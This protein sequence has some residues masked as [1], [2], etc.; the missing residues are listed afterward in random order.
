VQRGLRIH[1]QFIFAMAPITPLWQI[2]K[3]R[4]IEIDLLVGILL[5]AFV[6]AVAAAAPPEWVGDFRCVK[7]I[8]VR[9]AIEILLVCSMVGVGLFYLIRHRPR[10][11]CYLVDFTCYKPP[12]EREMNTEISVYITGRHE[13]INVDNSN[14]QWRIYLRSGLGEETCGSRFLFNDETVATLEEAWVEMEEGFVAVLDELF[15]KTCVK[16]SEIDIL[17]VNVSTFS[18]APSLAAWIVNRYKMKE[19]VKTFNISGMGCSANVIAVDMAKDLFKIYRDSY[20][21][22]VGSDNITLNANYGGNDRS[23]MVTNCLFRVGGNAVL[24]SNKAKDAA[25]A[26]MKLLHVVRTNVAADDEA[27]GCVMA[28]EDDEG[29]YGI[30]LRTSLIDIAGGAVRRNMATLGPKVLPITELLYY[31]SKS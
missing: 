26:K 27:Y 22:L 14:F 7:E 20:A 17:I 6:N 1:K 3:L 30:G 29:L 31:A 13:P 10:H 24:L 8:I 23:M 28:K 15:A 19:S 12:E 9:R 2:A 21:L 18:P 5:L 11:Q 4:F 25:R 16:P